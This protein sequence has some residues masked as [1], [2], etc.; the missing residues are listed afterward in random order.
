MKI[1]KE[2]LR[3][4]RALCYNSPSFSHFPN[5]GNHLHFAVCH[6]LQWVKMKIDFIL[7]AD[8]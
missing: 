7:N 6:G 8:A 2:N 5:L 4:P 3:Y 1:F